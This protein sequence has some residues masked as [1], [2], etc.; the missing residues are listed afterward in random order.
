MSLSLT[1]AQK[2]QSPKRGQGEN[3]TPRVVLRTLSF[4]TKMGKLTE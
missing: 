1:V 4:T 2:P 3:Q